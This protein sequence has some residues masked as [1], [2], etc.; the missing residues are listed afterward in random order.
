MLAL[1]P[2]LSPNSQWW[3]PVV[4]RFDSADE[5]EVWLTID[6]GP[7]PEDTPKILDLL[8]QHEAKATFFV[9]GKLAEQ[10]PELLRQ[11]VARGHQIANHSHT[12]PSGTWWCSPPARIAREIDLASRAIQNAIDET[13]RRFRA[14]VG[15]KNWWVH[16]RLRARGM[17]L[18]GWSSRGWDTVAR[19]PLLAAARVMHDATPGAIILVHEGKAVSKHQGFEVL[20]QL[21][22][23]LTQAGYRC[24]IPS[25]EQLQVGVGRP[26]P[27]S[28]GVPAG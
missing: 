27:M 23:R 8:D 21:L 12:H 5:P 22:P 15:M 25:D 11:V 10:N 19:T 3:G 13:P 1:Y 16:P 17:R 28:A 18:I 24:V 14:P 4:T 20:E 2:T 26:R 7:D 6:D 9:K